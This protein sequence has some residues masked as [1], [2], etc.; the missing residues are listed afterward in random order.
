MVSFWVNGITGITGV[1]G[2]DLGDALLWKVDRVASPST[3][4]Q[5]A[6]ALLKLKLDIC[7]IAC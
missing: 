2:V 1:T 6:T 3:E 4:E 5:T 7:N